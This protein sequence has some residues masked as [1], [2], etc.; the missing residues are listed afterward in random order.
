MNCA[1]CMK[2]ITAD[3]DADKLDDG[4]GLH[5]ACETPEVELMD[6]DGMEEFARSVMALCSKLR[7]THGLEAAGIIAALRAIAEGIEEAEARAA[8]K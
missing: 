7:D 6:V 4:R 8:S 1:V 5:C 3:E 2:P